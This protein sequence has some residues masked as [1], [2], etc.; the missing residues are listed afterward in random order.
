[1]YHPKITI[2]TASY[3]SAKTIEQCISSIVNQTYDNIE[4]I[5]IDG[6]STDGTVDIIKRYSDRIAYWVSEPD[7]G[8]YNALNKGIT[9]ATGDYIDII[10]SDD[11]LTDPQIIEQVVS[12]MQDE[13]DIL[14]CAE[15]CV[16]DDMGYQHLYDNVPARDKSTYSGGMVPHAAMFTKRDLLHKYP[17]DESYRIAGDYKFFLQCYYDPDVRIK[18]SD[19]IVAFFASGGASSHNSACIEEDERIYAELGLPFHDVCQ[20]KSRPLY[21]RAV[22]SI[23]NSLN[24]TEPVRRW[25]HMHIDWQKHHCN[26]AICRWCHRS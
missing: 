3:N 9:H 20:E 21:K 10:G 11:S 14:S 12:E 5:V 18:F 8:I 22:F 17:F 24:I 13:P 4:Y 23:T 19:L 7:Q 25:Y 16:D 15:W 2:I 6:A 1:M 26:N